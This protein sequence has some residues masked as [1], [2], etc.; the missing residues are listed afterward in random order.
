MV[1]HPQPMW[2]PMMT[3]LA[4]AIAGAGQRALPDYPNSLIQFHRI[5]IRPI[6]DTS[7][8]FGRY[9]A[10][11]SQRSEALPSTSDS[12]ESIFS[13]SAFVQRK[14]VFE[15]RSIFSY[16]LHSSIGCVWS[17][18]DT[19][20]SPVPCWSERYWTHPDLP[21][22]HPSYF[23]QHYLLQYSTCSLDFSFA[24]WSFSFLAFLVW[25]ARAHAAF[26]TC[27]TSSFSVWLARFALLISRTFAF[28]LAF[29]LLPGS[30]ALPFFLVQ[31]WCAVVAQRC[32]LP[33]S[34]EHH[35][36]VW[37]SILRVAKA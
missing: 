35:F 22:S 5:S 15:L 11:A 32:R 29:P 9:L 14:L 7:W 37:F 12:S 2:L 26:A 13:P 16:C 4:W 10:I 28:F 3:Q 8:P 18:Y 25:I 27:I 21:C 19:N 1:L 24:W 33:S 31:F 30:F 17:C 20:G 36:D 23:Y 6:T 34:I